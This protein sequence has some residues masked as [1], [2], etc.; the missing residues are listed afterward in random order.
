[1]TGEQVFPNLLAFTVIQRDEHEGEREKN[2]QQ[3]L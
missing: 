3:E 1:M 2:H